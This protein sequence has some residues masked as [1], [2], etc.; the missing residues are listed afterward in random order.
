MPPSPLPLEVLRKSPNSKARSRG[1]SSSAAGRT[2]GWS[3]GETA[4][5]FNPK[6]GLRAWGLGSGFR[7]QG[8]GVWGSGFRGLGFG[9][10]GFRV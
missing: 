2:S 8:F 10:L 7:V 1:S 3:L 4:G 9:A 6:P 5:L